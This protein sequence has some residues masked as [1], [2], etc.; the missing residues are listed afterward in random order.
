MT[1]PAVWGDRGP[2][3]ERGALTPHRNEVGVGGGLVSSPWWGESAGWVGAGVE[4]R[5]PGQ[6]RRA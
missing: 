4:E 1:E 6:R 5:R 3:Q 2:R